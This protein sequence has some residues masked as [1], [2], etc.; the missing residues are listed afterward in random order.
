M[1]FSL[2]CLTWRPFAQKWCNRV[3][4]I[5]CQLS[6]F[7]ANHGAKVLRKISS[8]C[9]L[10]FSLRSFEVPHFGRRAEAVDAGHVL[11]EREG[12]RLP[13]RHPPQPLHQDLPQRGRPLQHQVSEISSH[14]SSVLSLLDK[15]RNN[16]AP[17]ATCSIPIPSDWL[18]AGPKW[19]CVFLR[20]Q[21]SRVRQCTN[22]AYC[23]TFCCIQYH[24]TI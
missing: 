4:A 5:N 7:S 21:T 11:P 1:P 24:E 6:P 8:N 13:R 9:N 17:I 19:N 15:D 12:G 18:M 10:C 16:G 20:K 22:S 23:F 2:A 3:V 14:L